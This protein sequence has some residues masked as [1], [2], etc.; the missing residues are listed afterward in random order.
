MIDSTDIRRSAVSRIAA[1]GAALLAPLV[2]AAAALLAIVALA[3]TGGL[4]ALAAMAERTNQAKF[5]FREVSDFLANL[6]N[7]LLPLALPLGGIAFF[8]VAALLICG[9]PQA[10]QKGGW[11][12]AGVALALFSPTIIS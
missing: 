4:D 7:A 9:S 1:S 10:I 11:V 5:N 3:H 2:F 8:G 12:V 6:R